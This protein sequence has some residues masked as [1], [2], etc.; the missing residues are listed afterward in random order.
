MGLASCCC[1]STERCRAA[2]GSNLIF[3]GQPKPPLLTALLGILASSLIAKDLRG[4]GGD[5][6]LSPAPGPAPESNICTPAAQRAPR[7]S[8]RIGAHAPWRKGFCYTKSRGGP[9]GARGVTCKSQ[10]LE[11][12]EKNGR[13][14]QASTQRQLQSRAHA[15]N[16][17]FPENEVL[18]PFQFR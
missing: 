9:V 12:G 7:W 6:A 17:A 13:K 3:T 5:D 8:L 1:T 18:I 16:A 15:K 2:G 10:I 14:I 11:M 4:M